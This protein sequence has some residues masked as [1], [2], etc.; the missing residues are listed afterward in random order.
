MPPFSLEEAKK[1]VL[2]DAIQAPFSGDHPAISDELKS[3]PGVLAE[4]RSGRARVAGAFRSIKNSGNTP[5]AEIQQS[6]EGYLKWLAS[7]PE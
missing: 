6:M 7:F 2:L 3:D 4:V 5:D 1:Q